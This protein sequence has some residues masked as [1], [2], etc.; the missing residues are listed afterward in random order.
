MRYG[1]WTPLPHTVQPELALEAG[2]YGHPMIEGLETFAREVMPLVGPAP[3]TMADARPA[4][5]G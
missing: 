1:V 4:A 3:A 5:A 2:L